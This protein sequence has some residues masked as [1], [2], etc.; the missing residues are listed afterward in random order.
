MAP[1]AI[2]RT[3]GSLPEL[4]FGFG[5]SDSGFRIRD[6]GFRICLHNSATSVNPAFMGESK[7]PSFRR[8]IWNTVVF[9]L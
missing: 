9:K 3:H 5:I 6:F 7:G 4:I 1:S 8:E 2:M